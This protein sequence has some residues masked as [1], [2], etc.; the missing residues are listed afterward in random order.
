MLPGAP[1]SL[2][3]DLGW[4]GASSPAPSLGVGHR[5]D[6]E[7]QTPP[8][9]SLLMDGAQPRC[10]C[11]RSPRPPGQQE[12]LPRVRDLP[13]GVQ[14]FPGTKPS[15]TFC[16]SSWGLGLPSVHTCLAGGQAPGGRL[17]PEPA[18]LRERLGGWERA[19]HPHSQQPPTRHRRALPPSI[20]TVELARPQ[21]RED[22]WEQRPGWAGVA[23]P[24]NPADAC[25]PHPSACAA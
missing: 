11:S 9:T 18:K 7:S 4:G 25:C 21:D 13:V 6:V 3:V 10:S 8:P 5:W 20:R 23:A 24:G 22:M 12:R 17:P 2:R 16:F 15:P 1:D 19:P 14:V